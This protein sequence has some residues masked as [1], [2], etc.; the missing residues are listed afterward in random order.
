M[1]IHMDRQLRRFLHSFYLLLT[2]HL[3][4]YKPI[5]DLKTV[6]E[7]QQGSSQAAVN[8]FYNLAANMLVNEKKTSKDVQLALVGKGLSDS[9]AFTIVHNLEVEI[10]NAKKE[11]G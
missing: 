4:L 11:A 5:N 7:N 3:L 10:K 8:E 6:M 1:R 2:G 9:A